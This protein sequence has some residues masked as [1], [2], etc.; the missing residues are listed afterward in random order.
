MSSDTR[1]LLNTASPPPSYHSLPDISCR[2]FD[3]QS[4][5]SQPSEGRKLRLAWV[6]GCSVIL[7]PLVVLA[8]IFGLQYQSIPSPNESVPEQPPP[9]EKA[10]AIIGQSAQS[11]RYTSKSSVEQS[12]NVLQEEVQPASLPRIIS[13]LSQESPGFSSISQST[14][15][16]RPLGADWCLCGQYTL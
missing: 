1:P 6:G 16:S 5:K 7:I 8:I 11:A 9:V 10:V 14:S 13:G 2:H 12:T 3:G 4:Y 15:E